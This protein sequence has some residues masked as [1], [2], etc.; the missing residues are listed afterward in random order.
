MLLQAPRAGGAFQYRS[1]LRTGSDPNHEGVGRLLAGEDEN[2]RTLALAPGTLNVFRGKN[3]AH[4][5][6]AVEGSRARIVAVFSY[7]ES[8][9]VSFSEAERVGFYG[10]TGA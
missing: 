7:Y 2:V 1:A 6:S 10:R 4:R 8:P 9:G 3:T 5:V